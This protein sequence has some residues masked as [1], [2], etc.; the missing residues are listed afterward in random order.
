MVVGDGVVL[1]RGVKRW[2]GRLICFAVARVCLSY[3]GWACLIIWAS[4]LLGVFGL[5]FTYLGF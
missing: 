2:C 3:N 4:G 1:R 5:S